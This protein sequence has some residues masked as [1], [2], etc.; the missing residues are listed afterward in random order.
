M[1]FSSLGIGC[2]RNLRRKPFGKNGIAFSKLQSEVVVR[3]YCISLEMLTGLWERPWTD[4][5]D[6]LFCTDFRPMAHVFCLQP[7]LLHE[8]WTYV[9][10][11]SPGFS[12]AQSAAFSGQTFQM[13]PE[14]C[15]ALDCVWS[16]L[17][18]RRKLLLSS[19]GPAQILW[20]CVLVSESTTLTLSSWVTLLHGAAAL[21]SPS[22]ST[23]SISGDRYLTPWLVHTRYKALRSDLR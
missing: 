18:W 19:G 1:S 5:V 16:T 10:A 21:A 11:L 20:D 3:T 6:P 9:I 8:P 23:K 2:S 13:N 7:H 4:A 17:H 12:L 14:P 15:L 22:L